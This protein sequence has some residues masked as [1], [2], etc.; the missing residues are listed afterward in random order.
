MALSG[1]RNGIGTACSYLYSCRNSML[2]VVVI[3][4]VSFKAFSLLGEITLKS[5]NVPK[6]ATEDE[7]KANVK[8]QNNAKLFF[9]WTPRLLAA[10]SVV[11]TCYKLYNGQA[12]VLIPGLAKLISAK[13][14]NWL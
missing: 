7:K 10:T 12:T 9:H 1:I 2:G 13:A 14:P 6:D 11:F 3:N 8:N 4:Y 5:M